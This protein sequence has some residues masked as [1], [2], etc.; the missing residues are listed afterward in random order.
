MDVFQRYPFFQVREIEVGGAGNFFEIK[1]DLF[2][3]ALVGNGRGNA[4]GNDQG[5]D[6]LLA[7]PD[8][9]QLKTGFAIVITV[10]LVRILDRGRKQVFHEIDFP[11]RLARG[12]LE[13][14]GQIGKLGIAPGLELGMEP[15]VPF[16]GE[17]L[18]HGRYCSRLPGNLESN[19]DFS[20][21]RKRHDDFQIARTNS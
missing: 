10:A 9:R 21:I 7:E 6:L 17:F 16:K 13:F 18:G 15:D 4:L 19:C 20:I 14:F 11:G 3:E 8:V 2:F 12:D 1:I 5:D